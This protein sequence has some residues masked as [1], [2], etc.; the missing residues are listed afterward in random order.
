M[1]ERV[2]GGSGE[3]AGVTDDLA[4]RLELAVVKYARGAILRNTISDIDPHSNSF[5][6]NLLVS[7]F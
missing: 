3:D 1:V 6:F 4:R 7:K 2:V 5:K